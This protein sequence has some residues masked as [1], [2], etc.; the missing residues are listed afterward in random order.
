M[1]VWGGRS[2]GVACIKRR[3]PRLTPCVLSSPSHSAGWTLYSLVTSPA[4]PF[5]FA[6]NLFGTLLGLWYTVTA[7]SLTASMRSADTLTMVAVLST[8]IFGGAGAAQAFGA[9][10]PRVAELVWG[11]SCNVVLLAFFSAPLSTL[12]HVVAARSSAS[13]A[14]NWPL[15]VASLANAALWSAY[16]FAIHRPFVW[17]P[18]AA[19]VALGLAQLALIVALPSRPTGGP[20]GPAS[21]KAGDPETPRIGS[22]T[23]E[24]RAV[25]TGVEAGSP[26]GAA[27]RAAEHGATLGA[28]LSTRGLLAE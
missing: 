6:A 7:A 25:S 22:T 9:L 16:G 27:A 21:P 3:P 10:S 15:T 23:L 4:D 14:A 18:N 28:T 12:A 20:S 5:I 1:C 19:G 17:A 26:T 11:A 2:V 13:I 24:V 8:A